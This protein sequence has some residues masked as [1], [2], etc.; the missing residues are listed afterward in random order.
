MLSP[1]KIILSLLIGISFIFSSCKKDKDAVPY[2]YTDFY[3]YSTD[4]NFIALNAVQGWVYVTGGSR[5]VLIY[6]K[7]LNEF[8]AY[9]RPCTYN[10]TDPCGKVEVDLSNLICVD[11][12]CGSKFLITDGSVQTAPAYVPLKRYQ[13]TWDGTVL[14]VY[15]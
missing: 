6:R 12:C 3:I 1:N 15:N 5:G 8:M 11:N 10:T 4:P 9:D 7:S 2:V 13:T 14:H